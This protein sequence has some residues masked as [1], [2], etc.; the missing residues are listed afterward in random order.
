MAIYLIDASRPLHEEDRL[1]LEKLVPSRSVVVLNK[2][3][4]G[5]KISNAELKVSEWVEA[6]LISGHGVEDL[7]QAMAQT[8]EQGADLQTPPHAVISERH[9]QLLL[10][11][12]REARQAREFLNADV[13][14]NAVLASEHLRSAL[15]YLGQVT[16]RVY[17]DELLDNIFSRFC[18][19]K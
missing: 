2:I 7:R 18:I 3:D 8:L 10:Q 17:H 13:E 11:S 19:G 14:Q 16:G 5:R 4:L 15:E 6:S 12:H 1:R 9:R